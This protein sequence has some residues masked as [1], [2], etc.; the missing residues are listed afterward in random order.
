MSL[1]RKN[2]VQMMFKGDG[3]DAQWSFGPIWKHIHG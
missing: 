1:L 2:I 3:I